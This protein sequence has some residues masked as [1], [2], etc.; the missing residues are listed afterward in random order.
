VTSKI[1]KDPGDS[2]I[3]MFASRSLTMEPSDDVNLTGFLDHYKKVSAYLLMPMVMVPGQP[4]QFID[5]IY[6]LKRSLH[7]K[8]AAD[9]SPSDLENMFLKLRGLEP[10]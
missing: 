6:L 7:V 9:V 2:R 3:A 8:M 5:G 1:P 4:P 10:D